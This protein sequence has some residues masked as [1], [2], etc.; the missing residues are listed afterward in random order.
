MAIKQ[1]LS[2]RINVILLEFVELLNDSEGATSI[3]HSDHHEIQ[4]LARSSTSAA[5]TECWQSACENIIKKGNLAKVSICSLSITN[6]L[7]VF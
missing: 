1:V 2:Y 5:D 7:R 3:L 4:E 6:Q